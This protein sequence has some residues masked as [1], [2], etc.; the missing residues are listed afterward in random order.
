MKRTIGLCFIVL[1]L[2]CGNRLWA[3][4]PGSTGFPG[5][6]LVDELFAKHQPDLL[7]VGLYLVPPPSST[8]AIWP[9]ANSSGQSGNEMV[10]VAATDRSTIG[11]KA[12]CA[13]MDVLTS[14]D[15]VLEMN[16]DSGTK[17]NGTVIGS[18]FLATFH[19]GRGND[20]GLIEIGMKFNA[21]EESEAAKFARSV[22]RELEG[23]IR[24]K[25][26]FFQHTE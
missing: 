10:V 20:I 3:Q 9:G 16:G 8:A 5:Q 21:G 25:M 23:E 22:Q 1:L 4:E 24:S 17:I 12:S 11:H 14:Q 6:K 26:T 7:Y 19:D 13:D 2:I 18:T 15:S